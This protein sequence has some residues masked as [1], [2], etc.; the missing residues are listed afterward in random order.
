MACST[1]N[2]EGFYKEKIPGGLIKLTRCKCQE[3]KDEVRKSNK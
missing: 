1:C 3:K 2:D